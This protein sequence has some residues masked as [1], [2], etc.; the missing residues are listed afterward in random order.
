M[1][2]NPSAKLAAP[3]P[4]GWTRG[5]AARRLFTFHAA[6]AR[7]GLTEDML[8]DDA[9]A[10][11]QQLED[12]VSDYPPRLAAVLDLRHINTSRL[13]DGTRPDKARGRPVVDLSASLTRNGELV[14]FWWP[15]R[16]DGET[17]VDFSASVVK[18]RN[19][20]RN[21]LVRARDF[22]CI[23]PGGAALGDKSQ[24][25][26]DYDELAARSHLTLIGGA[27][28]H[29]I[30]DALAQA[31]AVR[32]VAAPLIE[33]APDGIVSDWSM[34]EARDEAGG[35][36]VSEQEA[37]EFIACFETLHGI[38][39]DVFASITDAVADQGRLTEVMNE[40][41]EAGMLGA[42]DVYQVRILVDT[43]RAARRAVTGKLKAA[44]EADFV[45]APELLDG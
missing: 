27:L 28:L 35:A 30:A 22:A 5:G 16:L 24:L 19:S 29:D 9:Q 43:F 12:A 11:L 37:L 45:E 42:D 1:S 17:D 18:A 15:G 41:E 25:C 38:P 13:R 39:V 2:K 26:D 33:I 8:S 36:V 21:E 14:I 34:E 6:L 7:A 20:R 23:L 3:D 10:A 31:C 32:T 40:L 4:H 44:E